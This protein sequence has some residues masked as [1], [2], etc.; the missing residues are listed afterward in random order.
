MNIDILCNKLELYG[1]RGIPLKLFRSF[2]TNRQSKVTFGN[3]SSEIITTNIGIPQGSALGPLLFLIYNNDLP[4][5]P[6]DIK[7]TLFADD[8]ALS[9]SHQNYDTLKNTINHNLVIMKDWMISNRLTLN[10]E[11]TVAILITNRNNNHSNSDL[12]IHNSLIPFSTHCTYLGTIIDTNLNFSSHILAIKAKVSR[13][14][15]IFYRIRKSL[16][17]D[18]R[19]K[20]YYS[21][22]YPFLSNNIIIWGGAPHTHLNTLIRQQKKILRL[23]G[24]KHYLEHTDPLFKQYNLLKINDIY[25]L[26]VL[27]YIHKKNIGSIYHTTHSYDTR[28]SNSFRPTFQRLSKTQNSIDFVGPKFWNELPDSIK[29]TCNYNSFKFKVKKFLLDKY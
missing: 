5:A 11:K 8:T 16:T 2:L 24:D 29:N 22:I 13:N 28:N 9:I 1:I 15:G 21:L 18:A 10:A 23:I 20:F 3:I 27:T 17:L 26:N 4:S 25:K 6:Q 7:T 14:T 12:N 19:L